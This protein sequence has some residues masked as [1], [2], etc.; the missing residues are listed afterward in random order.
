M[1]VRSSPSELRHSPRKK[2]PSKCCACWEVHAELGQI[3][4]HARRLEH[5]IAD[6]RVQACTHHTLQ[7]QA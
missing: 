1:A 4:A 6:F 7:Q 5:E 2:L 3:R